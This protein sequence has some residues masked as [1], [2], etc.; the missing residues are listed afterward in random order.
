MIRENIN[1]KDNRNRPGSSVSFCL[2]LAV[3]LTSIGPT[4]SAWAIQEQT[5]PPEAVAMYNTAANAFT[6]NQYELAITQWKQLLTEHPDY[7]M[8]RDTQYYIGVAHY[9]LQQFDEAVDSFTTLRDSLPNITDYRR[10]EKALFYMAISQYRVGKAA[11]AEGAESLR[12]SI[13][14]YQQFLENYES[15]ELTPEVLYFQGEALFELDQ[16][17]PEADTLA[18]AAASYKKL[19]DTYPESEKSKQATYAYGACLEKSGE[20]PTAREIYTKYID[21]YP[22]E[23]F[24]DEVRMRVGDTILQ[25]G[26]ARRT[27]GESDQATARFTEAEKIFAA[28]TDKPEFPSLAMAMNQRAFCLLNL[29]KYAMAADLYAAIGNEHSDFELY[30]DAVMSAGKYYYFGDKFDEADQWLTKVIAA[31]DARKT[32]ATH[33]L[34]KVRLKQQRFAEALQLANDALQQDTGSH[35]VNLQMDAADA[36]DGMPDRKAEAVA[37]YE[38]L[39]NDHPNHSLAPRALYYASFGYLDAKQYEDAA[40]TAEQFG[41]AYPN[42]ED[43]TNTQD[44]LAQ[45]NLRQGKHSEAR[46]IWTRLIAENPD[47]SRFDWWQSQVGWA[48]YLQSDYNGAIGWL[49]QSVLQMKDPVS[50][51]EAHYVIGSSQYELKN[52]VKAI[53]AFNASIKANEKRSNIDQV[54]TLAARAHF[55]LD[56]TDKAIELASNVWN[57]SQSPEAAYWLGEFHYRAGNFTAARD[58]YQKCL[59][60]QQPNDRQ[61]NALYGL[62]WANSSAK[63]LDG[64]I[65]AFDQLIK[66]YPEHRLVN[67][68][69]IGRGKARR[70]AGNYADAITDLNAFL[71]TDPD[72][73]NRVNGVYERALSYVKQED[74]KAAI[75]DLESLANQKASPEIEDD[76]LFELAWAYSEDQQAAKSIDTFQQIADNFTDSPLAAEANYHVAEDLYKQKNYD[77]AIGRYQTALDGSANDPRVAE[78]ATYKLAWCHFNKSDYPKSLKAFQLQVEKYPNG[79]LHA[80]GLSM[81]AE[82]HF[83][84]KQHDQAVTVYKVAIPAIESSDITNSVRILAPIHAAQSANKV[85]EFQTAVDYAKI[86]IDNHADSGY[87]ADAWYETG[88]AQ[89]GLGNRELAIAAWNEAMKLSLGKTG[90]RAR[91][92]IGEEHF[93]DKKYEDAITQFKLVIYGYGASELADEVAPWKAFAAYEAARCYY[94]Q[95]EGS[96]GEVRQSNIDNARKFFQVILDKF[97]NNYLVDDATKQLAVLDS[98]K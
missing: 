38:K 20:Y 19:L 61:P 41:K 21:K 47:N 32:E 43:Y 95:I 57:N 73:K 51:S 1:N 52:Y 16:V 74:W 98:I 42:D 40:R 27:S 67:S 37:A 50:I 89:K 60:S 96:Q 39:A 58:H 77:D 81:V 25:L 66:E 59:E 33:W 2:L 87:A 24:T 11:A 30:D 17:D 6:D 92:M 28:L 64:A 84:L 71:A 49:S 94:V 18:A 23:P 56:E 5:D 13:K 53:D 63:Q 36:L 82:S 69:L 14:T 86:V 76:I 75:G 35:T 72:E 9:N 10:S 88:V 29:Q 55:N 46:D 93:A 54:R 85:K 8:R 44:I 48:N 26:I 90:A 22:Q 65:Q 4:N 80:V 97:P 31:N 15:S 70:L 7:S 78:L 83:Q 45:V 34:C 62:A 12:Q 79:Q 3:L 91:C 68:A